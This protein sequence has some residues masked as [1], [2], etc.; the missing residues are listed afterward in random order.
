MN[1]NSPIPDMWSGYITQ[2]SNTLEVVPAHLYSTK[3]YISATTR[4]LTF[5]DTTINGRLDLTNMKTA[6]QLPNPQAQLIQFLR[7]KYHTRLRSDDSGEAD[8]AIV[9]TPFEDVVALSDGG[10]VN[11]TIGEKKYGPWKLWTLSAGNMVMGPVATGSD[12]ALS[13]GQV[14]GPMY[15]LTPYLAILPLQDFSLSIS[16]PGGPVTLSGDTGDE[17]PELLI[18]VLFD[19]Q[20][21]RAVQ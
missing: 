7:V 16:W 21:S 2:H 20:G 3:P 19:G 18:E 15:Q 4:E 9:P 14:G 17:H 13:Y 10:V 8:N 5:F 12:L 6:G 1:I 11:L